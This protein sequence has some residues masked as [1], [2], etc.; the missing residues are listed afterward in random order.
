MTGELLDLCN[1]SRCIILAHLSPAEL[2]VF[3][4]V[5]FI[6]CV[7]LTELC[8]AIVS[9]PDIEAIVVEL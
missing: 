4:F 5:R 9:Q 8:T 2:P 3:S 7:F 1:I 6:S